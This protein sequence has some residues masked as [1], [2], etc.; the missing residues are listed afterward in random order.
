M[1]AAEG[2]FVA[3][4]T[5]LMRISL[6]SWI[7][8]TASVSASIPIFQ[9]YHE[10]EQHLDNLKLELEKDHTVLLLRT[11]IIKYTLRY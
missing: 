4:L 7:C 9:Y 10:R 6:P 1:S 3:E 11:T 8:A 2:Q 5:A